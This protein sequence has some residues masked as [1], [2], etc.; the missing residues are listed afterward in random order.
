MYAERCT[1]LLD[2]VGRKHCQKKAAAKPK[3]CFS[4]RPTK[5]TV[6]FN[7]TLLHNIYLSESSMAAMINIF[8]IM[9]TRTHIVVF[10]GVRTLIACT[11]V[12]VRLC[13]C[14]CV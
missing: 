2:A 14:A 7:S 12:S 3:N 11:C 13:A 9:N 8:I 10:N 1:C 4:G 6:V 5:I